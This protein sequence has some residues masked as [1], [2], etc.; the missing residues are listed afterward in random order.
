MG[1]FI[2]LNFMSWTGDGFCVKCHFFSWK[3]PALSRQPPARPNDVLVS[4]VTVTKSDSTV[5]VTMIPSKCGYN[6]PL[7]GIK[8]TRKLSGDNSA[9]SN[10]VKYLDVDD[11]VLYTVERNAS[12]NPPLTGQLHLQWKDRTVSGKCIVNP[13]LLSPIWTIFSV[14]WSSYTLC[15][16]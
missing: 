2:C 15:F 4:N 7:L 14:L 5:C 6:F 3:L 13:I 16:C 9:N 1:V 8:D 12:A 11:G 10:L